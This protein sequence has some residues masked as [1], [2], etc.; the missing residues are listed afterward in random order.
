ML[1]N[2]GALFALQTRVPQKSFQDFSK[3]YLSILMVILHFSLT[4]IFTFT[5]SALP[6][7]LVIICNN[8]TQDLLYY[9]D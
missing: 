1:R 2:I 3:N 7:L 8:N 5:V 6:L 9:H 4:A